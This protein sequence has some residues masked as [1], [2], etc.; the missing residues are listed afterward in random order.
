MTSKDYQVGGSTAL[1]DAIGYGIEK[2]VSVQR[3]TAPDLQANKVLFVV[4]TDGLENASRHF[5]PSTIKKMIEYEEKKFKGEFIFM[6]ANIDALE[7]SNGWS[8]TLEKIKAFLK[9][10]KKRLNFITPKRKETDG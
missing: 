4:M 5:S 2:I 7:T 3:S 6:A 8:M 9:I 10:G 1:L